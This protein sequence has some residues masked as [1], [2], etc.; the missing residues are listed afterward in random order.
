MKIGSD[1]LSPA[2][3][4]VPASSRRTSPQSVW[5]QPPRAQ[6]RGIQ[7]TDRHA[8]QTTRTGR[9]LSMKDRRPAKKI[10]ASSVLRWF[11]ST[12]G[13][14][15]KADGV[16][17]RRYQSR[18]NGRNSCKWGIAAYLAGNASPRA[19]PPIRAPAQQRSATRSP[20]LAML[21]PSPHASRSCDKLYTIKQSRFAG[22]GWPLAS[23][24]SW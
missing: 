3:Y 18:S 11:A 24:R 14:E 22:I 8:D 6:P 9:S 19:K 17:C 23:I 4:P 16:G 10:C 13:M 7:G 2:S 5:L 15:T 21:R 20:V 12:S 1:Y